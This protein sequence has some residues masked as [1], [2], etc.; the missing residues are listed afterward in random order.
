MGIYAALEIP[1]IWRFDS[2]AHSKDDQQTFTI[3]RLVNGNYRACK[4]SSVLPMFN[5][6]ILMGFLDLSQTMGETSLI[7]HVRQWIKAQ[8]TAL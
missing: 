5:R 3:L 6:S 8:L 7:R 4:N 1:E 2:P